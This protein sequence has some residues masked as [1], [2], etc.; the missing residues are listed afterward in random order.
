MEPGV[1]EF[2][3]AGTVIPRADSVDWFVEG[4]P[5]RQMVANARAR[6]GAM[7]HCQDRC[8]FG[9]RLALSSLVN[10]PWELPNETLHLLRFKKYAG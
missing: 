6:F 1:S 3:Y 4:K 10:S 5:F 9:C 7:P 8:H 2:C